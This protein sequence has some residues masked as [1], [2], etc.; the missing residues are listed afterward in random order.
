M[1]DVVRPMTTTSD[2]S[3]I[4]NESWLCAP[5][6]PAKRGTRKR[7]ACAEAKGMMSSGAM[8]ARICVRVQTPLPANDSTTGATRAMT[9]LQTRL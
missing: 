3:H 6:H 4:Q 7:H 1:N 2:T 9:R 5:I 8:R